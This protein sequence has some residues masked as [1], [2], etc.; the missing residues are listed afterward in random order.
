MVW[1]RSMRRGF[2]LV[3]S[4]WWLR[5]LYPS[6]EWR[7]KPVEGRVFLSFDDGPH[8]TI[9]PWVMEQLASYGFTASF[10]LIGDN[11]RKYPDT[12]S[13]LQESKHSLGSHT[14]NHLNGWKTDNSKYFESFTKGHEL[15]QSDLFRPPYGRIKRS[16]VKKIGQK[17]RIIMW[18]VL[19][20]DFDQNLN[21][22]N[23]ARNVIQ[24]MKPGSIIVFHDSEKA[25]PRLEK[26]LP[27]VLQHMKQEGFTSYGL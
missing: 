4:P 6:L 21:A 13:S 18:D 7:K 26:A 2:Y 16:Q 10:F 11:I 25:W 27:A 22:E 9:T 23:C 1:D 15:V 17:H 8:P 5:W 14:M 20:G 19:S 24:N 12:Y 3:K